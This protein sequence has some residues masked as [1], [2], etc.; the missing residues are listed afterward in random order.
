[1]E[2]KLVPEGQQQVG[3]VQ[4][5]LD[6]RK[7]E[8]FVRTQTQTQT[9]TLT[10]ADCLGATKAAVKWDD[11]YKMVY[12]TTIHTSEPRMCFLHSPAVC[13]V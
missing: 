6:A 12:A 1:M 8:G 11:W 2:E 10:S 3:P 5:F 9:I 13:L 4:M 7:E